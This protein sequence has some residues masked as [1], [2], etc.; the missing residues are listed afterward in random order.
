[1]S[2]F[3]G[4]EK[5]IGDCQ[6]ASPN[7][8]AQLHC[9]VVEK[10]QKI[11]SV[12]LK[13]GSEATRSLSRQTGISLTDRKELETTLT[14][15]LGFKGIAQFGSEVTGKIGREITLHEVRTTKDDFTFR[16]PK[17][18]YLAVLLF[19]LKRRIHLKYVGQRLLGPDTWEKTIEEWV[20]DFYELP[21]RAAIYDECGCTGTPDPRPDGQMQL[22]SKNLTVRL[23]FNRQGDRLVF[24]AHPTLDPLTIRLHQGW[25]GRVGTEVISPHLSFLAGR[26]TNAF[27][28]K[29]S[30]C[31]TLSSMQL[32]SKLYA[33]MVSQ[34]TPTRATYPLERKSSA[35]KILVIDDDEG[36]LDFVK[37]SLR[38][39]EFEIVDASSGA[40]GLS[41]I[42]DQKPDLVL[43]D[44]MMPGMD[45]LSVLKDLRSD[46]DIASTPILLLSALS[47]FLDSESSLE[48]QS[49]VSKPL[50]PSILIDKVWKSL[51]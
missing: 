34:L 13:C 22:E 16:A 28:A 39:A 37:A 27:D 41:I 21:R 2:N 1:M 10:W 26:T 29:I 5:V 35:K 24:P 3:F 18:G 40:D 14:G 7:G 20:D 25:K 17:C 43:L 31:P 33:E 19:Q 12:V 4:G 38:C 47:E 50:D 9:K 30:F 8:K 46:P 42:R 36:I 6:V 49:T 48:V 44:T 15:S 23:D 32:E 45:G 11:F 51:P